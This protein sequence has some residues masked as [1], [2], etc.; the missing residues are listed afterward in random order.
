MGNASV[1]S[2]IGPLATPTSPGAM[3][4]GAIFS[5]AGVLERVLID[6][7][8]AG[9]N[10]PPALCVRGSLRAPGYPAN[11]H[12]ETYFGGEGYPG[13]WTNCSVQFLSWPVSADG[14][15]QTMTIHGVSV[16][17]V[18]AIETDTSAFQII[19]KRGASTDGPWAAYDNLTPYVEPNEKL[20]GAM[21]WDG[22]LTAAGGAQLATSILATNATTGFLGIPVCKG[23]PTGVPTADANTAQLVYDYAG[24]HLYVL[25]TGLNL[26]LTMTAV[27]SDVP[28]FN[29][30]TLTDGLINQNGTALMPGCEFT[31]GWH[32]FPGPAHVYSA[33]VDLGAACSLTKVRSH[34]GG[35]NYGLAIPNPLIISGSTDNVTFTTIATVTGLVSLEQQWVET[36]FSATSV[37]YL[38]VGLTSETGDCYM[39]I[40]EI[41]AY[42]SSAWRILA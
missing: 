11:G 13:I 28:Y 35:G 29:F 1:K 12:Y 6:N 34:I 27:Y 16:E 22:K 3:P 25:W 26:A 24:Q 7:S 2:I 10:D 14:A 37:R 31:I 39:G 23:V 15:M 21:D 20:I 17:P 5:R 42:T 19:F 40:G 38:R 30:G 36:T 18:I 9:A 32:H 8:G 41:E 4:A 33:T